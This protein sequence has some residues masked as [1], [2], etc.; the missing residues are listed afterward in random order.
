MA[1]GPQVQTPVHESWEVAPIDEHLVPYT[2]S[3][4][5]IEHKLRTE[6]PNLPLVVARPSIVVGHTTL[7]CKPSG[8]IFWVFRMAQKLQRFTCSLDEKIDVIPVDY[9]ADALV[10]LA[11]KENLQHDLYH[12]SAGAVA[13][14]T[15]GNIE[16]EMAIGLGIDSIGAQYQRISSAAIGALAHDFEQLVGPCNRRLMLRAL[17]LYAGF[18]DLN[19]VFDNCRLL[20]EGVLPPP[21]FTHYAGLCAQSS[22][23]LSIPEQMRWDFK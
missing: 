21:L 16:Q 8:S 6:L 3:K 11:T 20:A 19:Y 7:G 2:A 14:C 1:C 15:F 17:R 5:A 13:S 18:A 9:C 22:R 23:H 4:A 10:E 12:V